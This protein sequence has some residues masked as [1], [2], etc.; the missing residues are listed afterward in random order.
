M[1]K[2]PTYVWPTLRAHNPSA[3]IDFLVRAFGFVEVVRYGSG[4]FVDHAELSWPRGGG[5]MIGTHR[6]NDETWPVAPGSAGTYVVTDEPDALFERAVKEGAKMVIGPQ[7]TDYGSREFVVRDIEGNR[8]SFGTY[9]G[10]R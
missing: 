7:D 3:L 1:S 10:A 9:G 4:D 5:L 6:D 8:W 2:P